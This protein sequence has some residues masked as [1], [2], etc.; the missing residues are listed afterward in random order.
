MRW[1]TSGRGASRLPDIR[2][3]LYVSSSPAGISRN[4]PFKLIDSIVIVVAVI[5]V[6]VAASIIVVVV[7]DVSLPVGSKD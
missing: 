2:I 4:P 7:E 1:T 6:V 3:S 5:V